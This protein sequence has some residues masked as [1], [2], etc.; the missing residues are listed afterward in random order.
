MFVNECYSESFLLEILRNITL[1]LTSDIGAKCIYIELNFIEMS[2]Q[3]QM[4]QYEGV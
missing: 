4:F 1:Y 2:F 3:F